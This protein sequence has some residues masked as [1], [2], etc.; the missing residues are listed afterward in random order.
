[1]A[2]NDPVPGK[3]DHQSSHPPRLLQWKGHDRGNPT[4]TSNLPGRTHMVGMSICCQP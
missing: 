3:R 4:T 2:T 1:M